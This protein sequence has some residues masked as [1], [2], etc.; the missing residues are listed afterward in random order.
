[1][2]KSNRTIEA[3]Y[4]YMDVVSNW[5]D[6]T[7]GKLGKVDS[8]NEQLHPGEHSVDG[9]SEKAS[10]DELKED[11]QEEAKTGDESGD[12]REPKS[13]TEDEKEEIRDSIER[14]KDD[15]KVG[16]FHKITSVCK[17]EKSPWEQDASRALLT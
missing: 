9:S 11:E 12:T 16:V 4:S 8:K 10:G 17:A 15:I 13:L 7:D 5:L 1:M 14:I 3:I 6:D 2:E